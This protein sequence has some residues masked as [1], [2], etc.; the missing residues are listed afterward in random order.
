MYQSRKEIRENAKR[1]CRDLRQRM[2]N[3]E[4]I[5][6][7]AVRNRQFLGKRFL[8]QHPFFNE[9]AG[10][11]RFYIVDFYCPED[12][13]IVE[14]DGSSHD[15]REYED[16]ERTEIIEANSVRLVRF[17]N[18]DVERDIADVLR[19]LEGTMKANSSPS[20]RS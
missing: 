13:I 19:S 7:E 9:A 5:F 11:Y 10:S 14:L 16:K 2:T 17:R 20:T 6:W 4:S 15:G 12:R 18:E 1:L 8:R 3:A